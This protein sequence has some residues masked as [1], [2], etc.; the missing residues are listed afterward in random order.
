MTDLED[1]A[2]VWADDEEITAA[3]EALAS[4]DEKREPLF[5]PQIER[6]VSLNRSPECVRFV[7]LF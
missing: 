1:A 6:K 2:I 7:L 5:A 3:R 4:S